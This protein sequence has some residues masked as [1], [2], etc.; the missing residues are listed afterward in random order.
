[1][2]PLAA[3]KQPLGTQFK[4][5]EATIAFTVPFRRMVQNKGRKRRQYDREK[6]QC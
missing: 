5:L 3:R 4:G 2:K 1:M 6:P